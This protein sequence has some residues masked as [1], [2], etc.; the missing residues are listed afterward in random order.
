MNK[1]FIYLAFIF[2]AKLGI[3]QDSTVVI[4]LVR[5]ISNEKNSSKN[6]FQC[7]L[8]SNAYNYYKNDFKTYD[9]WQICRLK[10][11]SEYEI[12]QKKEN[13]REDKLMDS[14]YLDFFSAIREGKKIV[15]IDLNKNLNFE[16]DE[17]F[18]FDIGEFDKAKNNYFAILKYKL[19][20]LNNHERYIKIRPFE[21]EG[22]GS[23]KYVDSLKI[24]IS[25]YDDLLGFFSLNGENYFVKINTSADAFL[26]KIGSDSTIQIG[27]KGKT[28]FNLAPNLKL[29]ELFI[30]E[31]KTVKVHD[32]SENKDYFKITFGIIPKDFDHIVQLDKNF[33]DFIKQPF[34]IKK[35]YRREKNT[36]IFIWQTN[37]KE[38]IVKLEKIDSL[39]IS[40]EDKISVRG[41]LFN[42]NSEN[43]AD[44]LSNRRLLFKNYLI[45]QAY[46]F[47]IFSKLKT[48]CIPT[49][50]IYNKNNSLIF[51]ECNPEINKIINFLD[52]L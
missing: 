40:Y 28:Y 50:L 10:I 13:P 36:L 45:S 4:N 24:E 3:C 27:I 48:D 39:L 23:E 52:E 38:S 17:K 29:N 5:T 9:K 30:L 42:E 18:E 16:D 34:S 8:N 7:I 26:E 14:C 19:D 35:V 44:I 33:E 2:V 47:P 43:L 49:V 12:S 46:P 20:C 41:I 37:S 15:I 32:V 25:T 1:Y 22:D 6:L 31:N 21:I 11:S 51:N